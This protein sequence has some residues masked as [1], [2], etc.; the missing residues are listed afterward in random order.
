MK[1][2]KLLTSLL[3]IA[4]LLSSMST[5]FAFDEGMFMPDQIAKLP[6]KKL[7]LKIK[8]AAA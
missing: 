6:L 5:A 3:T 1:R 7:G 2:N 4:I 8:P